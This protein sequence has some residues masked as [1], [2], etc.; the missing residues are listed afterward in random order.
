L[1]HALFPAGQDIQKRAEQ[2]GWLVVSFLP[3]S[4]KSANPRASDQQIG[5]GLYPLGVI[6]LQLRAI[7][8]ATT[9]AATGHDVV[10][11]PRTQSV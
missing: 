4:G 10:L 3:F 11:K 6:P 2:E 8:G 9:K 7:T 1:N 5:L